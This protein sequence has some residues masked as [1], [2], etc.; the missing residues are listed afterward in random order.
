MAEDTLPIL[1]AADRTL[2][3][4]PNTG[5]L[6]LKEMDPETFRQYCSEP[7]KTPPDFNGDGI[8]ETEPI[9]GLPAEPGLF[10]VADV[11]GDQ[12]NDLVF[13]GQALLNQTPQW[14]RFFANNVP[15]D[16]WN[17]WFYLTKRLSFYQKKFGV[18]VKPR[19]MVEEQNGEKEWELQFQVGD[20][21]LRVSRFPDPTQQEYE[22]GILLGK[23]DPE[24]ILHYRLF[25]R[26]WGMA[27]R[28]GAFIPYTFRVQG[29][30]SPIGFVAGAE[31]IYLWRHFGFAV[32]YNYGQAGV[33][34]EALFEVEAGDPISKLPI[35]EPLPMSLNFHNLSAVPV[36][37]TTFFGF[38]LHT[39]LLGGVG[40]FYE[41]GVVR[42][43]KF[44]IIPNPID[45]NQSIVSV[46]KSKD[47]YQSGGI[48]GRVGTLLEKGAF[49]I[50]L[51]A[52]FDIGLPLNGEFDPFD[53]YLL[54]GILSLT[55]GYHHL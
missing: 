52:L 28:F 40:P 27:L 23:E 6:A 32:E 47:D 14:Q 12:W 22:P 3:I 8:K 34:P 44:T 18:T 49:Q 46:E 13:N 16:F 5:A 4:D 10:C 31:W 1:L 29:N 53:Q 37:H 42:K 54:R 26:K 33:F 55:V 51:E 39:H 43:K 35:N 21:S 15:P 20:K 25:G 19:L 45:L 36:L 2:F 48:R 24:E 50:G 9:P 41:R 17:D 38:S 7:R 30:T 11:N